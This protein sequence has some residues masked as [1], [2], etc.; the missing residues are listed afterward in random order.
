MTATCQLWQL[1]LR[2]FPPQS[3]PQRLRWLCCYLPRHVLH[4]VGVRRL[5]VV[6]FKKHR[7][8]VL[9]CVTCPGQLLCCPDHCWVMASPATSNKAL[10]GNTEGTNSHP[11]AVKPC[12]CSRNAPAC[13]PDLLQVDHACPIVSWSGRMQSAPGCLTPCSRRPPGPRLLQMRV[14]GAGQTALLPLRTPWWGCCA[15]R[16]ALGSARHGCALWG[17]QTSVNKWAFTA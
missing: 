17:R 7:Y 2:P 12:S 5:I 3:A 8:F 1:Q 14:M 15:C 4:Q 9:P 6:L 16:W 11:G 13:H 10:V